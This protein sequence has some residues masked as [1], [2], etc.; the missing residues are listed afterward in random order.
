M[1]ALKKIKATLFVPLVLTVVF[2]SLTIKN[3]PVI[4]EFIEA[5]LV[6]YRFK[7]RNLISHPPVPDTIVIVTVDEKSLQER[8]R[9]PW[10]RSLQAELIEQVFL[11]SPRAVGVDIFYPEPETPAS[12]GALARVFEKHRGRLIVGLGFEAEKGRT[13][14]GEI[15]DVLYD[16]AIS[17]IENLSMVSSV[18][19][20]RALLPHEP[21]K[22]AAEYGHVYSLA[23]RDGKLRREYLYIQYGAEY[24]PS[25]ALQVAR[26]ALDVPLD[27]VTIFGAQGVALGR[28]FIPTDM[29]GR[30]HINYLGRERTFPY[31]SATDV[32]SGRVSPELFKDR[33]VLIGTSA[34][35]IYDLKNTP[36]SANMPGVEKHATIIANIM[37][38]NFIRKAPV[39]IDVLAVMLAGA[40]ALLMGARMG[41]LPSFILYDIL[42]AF[43]LISNQAVFT[44]AGLRVNL[45]YPLLT[46]LTAG[47][48][49]ISYRYLIEERRAREIRRMFSNYVTERVVN[50]LIRNPEMARLGGARR[51]VTVLFSDLCGF[52]SYSEKHAPE[53]VVSILNEYLTAMTEVIFR[54]EGTLD[55]FIGDAIVAFWGAPLRQENHAELA[56]RCALHMIKRLQDLQKK[57][58]AEGKTPLSMGIGINTGEVLVGNIGAE[59]KKMD[60]T[61]IGDQVNI[62]SRVE[63]LTRKFSTNIL[64]TE[65]PLRE[66]EAMVQSNRIGHVSI[67]GVATVVVKGKEKPVK[68]YE[69]S[70][71]PDSE[72]SEITES[73]ETGALHMKEK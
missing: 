19:A 51:E 24:F 37:G 60:Y 16:Y 44:L 21:I 71:L 12:D 53:D 69:I 45:V 38:N 55:K 72:R 32:L 2:A 46:V 27:K 68:I 18:H 8:G 25:L 17:R 66:I 1:K 47:A 64:M 34:L 20:F 4:D 61:V 52:T 70:S 13:H 67:R 9:W 42:L 28:S 54:W 10:K 33:I 11:G 48:F 36:F 3:P 23:D 22:S 30:M 73:G 7:V 43:I 39:Y 65:M 31:V 15:D 58:I 26:T 35:S 57:W 56:V 40:A 6:D 14:E 62:G 41:A 63:S 5:L 59:G 49:I 29:F 50:E